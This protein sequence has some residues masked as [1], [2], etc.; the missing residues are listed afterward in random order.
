VLDLAGYTVAPGFVD[1]HV[2]GAMGETF[3]SCSAAGLGKMLQTFARHGTTAVVG[4]LN[5]S[6]AE[7]R[8]A[9]LERY[10]DWR[11]HGQDG[12][13]LLGLYLEG[14]YYNPEF[15]GA[16]PAAWLH[17]PDPKEYVPWLD[18]FGELLSVVSLAPEREGAERLI[19]ELA[20]RGIAAAIGHSGAD[21][22]T[23][24]RAI[25][26]G[27][28]LVTHVYCA[29]STFHRV[30]AEKHLGVAEVGLMRDELT[31][32]AVADGRHLPRELLKLV[33]KLKPRE[34]VCAV[35]D[36]MHATGL[37]AGKYEL[38]GDTVWVE[39]GVAYRADRQRY[40]GSVLT[41]DAAVRNLVDAGASLGDAVYM[42]TE[43]PS[44]TVGEGHCKGR[45]ARGYDADLA[46]LT[47]ELEVSATVCG[48]RVV[49]ASADSPLAQLSRP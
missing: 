43:V 2:N 48:G 27:A 33:L 19:R 4:A 38:M 12:A 1:I 40:A 10:R 26:A 39:D 47:E 24:S 30:G 17:D 21:E 3:E 20:D 29:Q 28:R 23:M 7:D 42:A 11:A 25:S 49:Y 36:A 14:P 15:R 44:R 46:I 22:G 37:A 34:G 6:P 18:R 35:T 41:M 32:E 13:E 5:T 31:V 45:L 16:H 8:W 9:S